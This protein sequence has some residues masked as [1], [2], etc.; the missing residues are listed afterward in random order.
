MSG[1][2]GRETQAGRSHRTGPVAASGGGWRC[3]RLWSRNLVPELGCPSTRAALSHQSC[4]DRHCFPAC[5][6]PSA[7]RCAHSSRGVCI[8][9]GAQEAAFAP[10]APSAWT[11]R[12]PTM[13]VP[14]S[15]GGG[16]LPKSAGS[17]PEPQLARCSLLILTTSPFSSAVEEQTHSPGEDRV[18]RDSLLKHRF[19]VLAPLSCFLRRDTLR[20]TWALAGCPGP[21]SVGSEEAG[22]CER[23]VG[24]W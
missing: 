3:A 20:G 14:C 2:G 24:L 13:A 12:V 18:Q 15:V 17:L 9:A 23:E 8:S 16:A 11:A 10:P 7:P 19:L 5:V 22:V 6:P 1:R 21:P 4:P